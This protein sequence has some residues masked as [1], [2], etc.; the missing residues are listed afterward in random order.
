MSVR[1][2]LKKSRAGETVS[3]K[4]PLVQGILAQASHY[5]LKRVYQQNCLAQVL[6]IS[7]RWDMFSLGE[8][9]CSFGTPWFCH[10]SIFGST[11]THSIHDPL[12]SNNSETHTKPY[13][14]QFSTIPKSFISLN[15][16]SSYQT[17]ISQFGQNKA[18]FSIW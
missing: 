14:N 4:T 7:P 12:S 2:K 6:H 3:P 16:K 1:E 15:L 9:S 11:F 17:Q 18:I 10:F 5:S 13:F 8:I